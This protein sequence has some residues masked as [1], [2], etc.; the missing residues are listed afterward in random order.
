MREKRIV[1]LDLGA[2]VAG[3]GVR[4]EFEQRLKGVLKDVQDS[5]GQVILFIDELHTLVGAGAAEGSMDAS[6]LLKPML[7]RGELHCV[8]ATTLDEYR[9]YIE[10]DAA[11]ARRF[12]P[13]MVEEPSLEDTIS[14]LR[15]LKERYE[16]HHGV[17]IGDQAVVS[18]A[19]LANR[20]LNDRK[21]PDKAVDLMDEAAA[22]LRLQQ[23][24]K[25]DA[26]EA[27]DRKI[28]SKRI[29]VEGLRRETDKGSVERREKLEAD[30]AESEVELNDLME[31]W[32]AE[33]AALQDVKSAKEDLEAARREFMAAERAGDWARASE[34]KYSTIPD[35]E[36][37]VADTTDD[38]L[39]GDVMLADTVTHVDIARVISRST[40]IPLDDLLASET[41]K[42]LHMEEELS[43]KV[44][45]QAE[46]VSAVSNCI[47]LSRAGLHSHKRPLGVFMF[48]GPTG[49]GKTE[50]TKE[51]ARFLF[52][53][54]RAM[55]RI[56]C[57]EYGERFSTSRLLGAP[58][59]YVGYEEGGM[60]TEAVRRRPY[61]IILFDEFEKAHIEV[62]NLLLSVF[63]E[64]HLTDSHGRRVDFRQTVIILTS[65]LG[66]NVW[67]NLP[68]ETPTHDPIVHE[69]VMEQVRH[70]FA[71]EFLNRLDDTILFHK[72]TRKDMN[73]IVGLRLDEIRGLLVEKDMTM[74]CTD[75]AVDWL[76]EQ[77][78]DPRFGARPLGRVLQNRVL[79]PL[80]KEMLAGDIVTGDNVH[81]DIVD[82]ELV[83]SSS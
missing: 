71:P 35:L 55:T 24:S 67:Q 39:S 28:M 49:V 15:G 25:P 59:G 81:V 68:A 41:Q 75:A 56:D 27:L 17:K 3:A 51:L 2:L 40:G 54:P 46:A 72:L 36:A 38:D 50:L 52:D 53:D 23:E 77:S 57:Q 76:A 5:N 37:K 63:D 29:E 80:A 43:A 6:N 79:N 61:Q 12:Q 10:K 48:L 16:L 22:S 74:T 42:L 18:A 13:V 83:V 14:I 45:G 26:I 7:A 31:R 11:L 32:N 34:L 4:G 64:G 20:Y 44:I 33:R 1:S 78:Y 19:T 73:R 58:P 60:L 21:M 69:Q 82:G 70:H 65:N 66:T 47:R 9:K 8:G 30:I 62:S